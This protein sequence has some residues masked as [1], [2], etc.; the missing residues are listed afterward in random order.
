MKLARRILELHESATLAVA[1]RAAQMKAQGIDVISFG[2]G[3]PDF[4][5][6]EHVAHAGANA[7]LSG[8]TK[9]CKPASGTLEARRAV[10]AKFARDNGLTYQPDQ[11][12][13]TAGGK[14]AVYLAVHAV[15]DPG[16]EVVIPAPYW[17]SYPEIV[18]LAGGTPVFVAGAESRDYKLTPNDLARV[19]TP[20]TKMLI[21]NSPSNPTGVTYAPDEI[22][23]I[24]RVLEG[25]NLYVLSDE[26]YDQLVFDGQATKSYAAVSESAY[27]QAITVNAGSKTY[28]MTGW[29]IGYAAGPA[30]VIGAMDKLQSQTTSGAAT[31]T[32]D[33]LAAALTA[34]Q[35]KVSAMRSEYAARAALMWERLSAMPGVHCPRPTGAFYCF[36]KV[37]KLFPG[38]GFSG[39]TEFAEALLEK[40]RVAVVPGIGFG[41][42]DHVRLSYACSRREIHEGLDRLQWFLRL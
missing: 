8:K 35:E 5:T 3:E 6:P 7:I 39:S 38:L 42:D 29:R 30:D 13:I 41:M 16:D 25:R 34:D 40:A 24:A 14:M 26:I 19:L 21:L 17:V 28:S 27:E 32:Q 37:S 10:C 23:A 15:I 1:A 20:R 31:F 33:A 18:R 36:P 9:Y 2:A 12:I 4:P 22:E 11:V